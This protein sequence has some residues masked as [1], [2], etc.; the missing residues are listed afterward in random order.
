MPFVGR[1]D[2]LQRISCRRSGSNFLLDFFVFDV[3][4]EGS[5]LDQ[6]LPRS[7]GLEQTGRRAYSEDGDLHSEFFA[8]LQRNRLRA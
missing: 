1:S 7:M 2:L 6:R 8:T 5:F 3:Q 4:S